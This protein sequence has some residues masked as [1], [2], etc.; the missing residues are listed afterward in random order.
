MSE[1]TPSYPEHTC[2]Y[3]FVCLCLFWVFWSSLTSGLVLT[4]FLIPLPECSLDLVE[5]EGVIQ[6]SHLVF[7]KPFTKVSM[8]PAV[9]GG[10]R[11]ELT[12]AM[13]TRI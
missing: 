6:T 8:S 9:E 4:I 7:N 10:L 12:C 3:L 5:E 1:A 13:K 11:A 2:F